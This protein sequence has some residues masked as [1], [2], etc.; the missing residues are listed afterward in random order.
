MMDI[1]KE[2]LEIKRKVL[3]NFI[4]KG[5]YPYS[6]FYLSGIKQIRGK[7][8]ANHFSTIGLVGLN[9]ALLNFIGENIASKRGRKFALEVMNFM[10]DRLVEYQ[11]E[12]GQLYNLEATPAE[13]TAYRLCR[14]DKEKYPE[15]VAAGTKKIPYYTNSSQLPVD[16]TNDAFEALK[17]QDDIQCK[18]TGGTVLHL[19]LGEKVSDIQTVK[20]LVKKIF[21]NFKL[22]YITF[23]PTFS[24]CPSHGYLEGEHFLCPKCT[25]KQPCEVYSRIV[26]YYRPITQWNEGKQE[27]FKDRKEFK[28]GKQILRSGQ[29]KKTEL[30]T[31]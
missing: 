4:E 28:I 2:S 6:K 23:T 1:S 17:L 14:K 20:T 18:Y 13:S 27:E 11:K 16:Y 24:I 19:F 26:G 21:E 15:I 25:I 3:E 12:T 30:I 7:Y 10:R 22:P 31:A 9:E 5:L 8:Y 29:V